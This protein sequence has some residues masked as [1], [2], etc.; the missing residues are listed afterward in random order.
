MAW[1]CSE[2]Q[3]KVPADT[4]GPDICRLGCDRTYMQDIRFSHPIPEIQPSRDT[5]QACAGNRGSEEGF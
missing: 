2:K 1:G 5:L 4:H 3:S